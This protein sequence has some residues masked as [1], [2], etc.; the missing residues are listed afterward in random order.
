M[1]GETEID[2]PLAVDHLRHLFE[3]SNPS[4]VV[5][6]EVIVRGEEGGNF[7]LNLDVGK[8][9]R[10][11]GNDPLIQRCHRRTVRALIDHPLLM[12]I[13]EESVRHESRIY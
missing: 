7:I 6:I 8:A 13:G 1:P 4:N 11:A 3:D 2:E 12:I 5:L 10:D 9:Q